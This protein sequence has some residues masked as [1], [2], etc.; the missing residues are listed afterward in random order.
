MRLV[1]CMSKQGQRRQSQHVRNESAYPPIAA[2]EQRSRLIGSV[3]EGD[4]GFAI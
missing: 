1:R 3:P 2:G 4:I